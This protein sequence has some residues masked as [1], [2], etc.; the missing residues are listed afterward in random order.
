MEL[1]Q[2][3][4]ARFIP[5]KFK[6]DKISHL[7]LMKELIF[8]SFILLQGLIN[9]KVIRYRQSSI[10]QNRKAHLL[11]TPIPLSNLPNT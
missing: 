7:N 10:K 11:Q 8:S 6:S 5:I 4:R 2:N 1:I 9:G 3:I